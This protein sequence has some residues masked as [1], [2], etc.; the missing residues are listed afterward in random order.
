MKRVPV[1]LEERVN[2]MAAAVVSGV[3]VVDA[4]EQ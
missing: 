2:A 1:H 4:G 3:G